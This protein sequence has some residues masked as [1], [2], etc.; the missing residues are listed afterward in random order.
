M[1]FSIVDWLTEQFMN[2][3]KKNGMCACIHGLCE[4]FSDHVRITMAAQA[5]DGV[6]AEIGRL[7]DLNH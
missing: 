3:Y 4:F 1:L 2:Y 7:E 6:L 5:I